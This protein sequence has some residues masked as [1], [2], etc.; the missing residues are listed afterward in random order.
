MRRPKKTGEWTKAGDRLWARQRGGA[1]RYYG[2]FRDFRAEG[3]RQ[4]RLVVPGEKM[5]TAD[6]RLAEQLMRKRL[7]DLEVRRA[8]TQGRVVKGL[9]RVTPLEPFA[10]EHLIAKKEAGKVTDAWLDGEE[11]RL[12]RAVTFFDK[13]TDLTAIKVADVRKWNEALTRQG[14]SGGTRRQHLNTLSNLFRRAQAEERVQPGYNPVTAM[15]D[16][17]TAKSEEAHWLEVPEAALFLEAARTFSPKRSKI[18]LPFAF[19]LLATFLLTGGRPAEVLGLEVDDVSFDRQLVTF[20]PNQWRRLKTLSSRRPVPLWPQLKEILQAY[21][22]STDHPPTRLLFP[23][24]RTGEEGMITDCRKMLDAIGKRIGFK[25][26]E[27]N[28]YDFRHTYCAARLQTKDGDT[29]VSPYTVGRE[30]GHGGAS[31]VNRVYGHLGKFRPRGT[32]V[33]Y[34][35]KAFKKAKVHDQTVAEWLAALK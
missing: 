26:R 23:S 21:V 31:L 19:P 18:A 22:F 17:P 9:P 10:A 25:R 12:E 32:V 16:K 3:G 30:L 6:R 35:V 4:E 8:L 5:A 24:W 33:E 11:L 28:L 13:D 1:V 20:R 29:A 14:L 27:L 34:R 7:H 2:E 15:M